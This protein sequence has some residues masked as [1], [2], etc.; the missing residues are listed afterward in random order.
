M[1]G[2]AIFFISALFKNT[3][4][5]LTISFVF[6]GVLIFLSEILPSFLNPLNLVCASSYMKEFETINFFGMPIQSFAVSIC[7][8]FIISIIFTI[9]GIKKCLKVK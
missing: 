9:A 2:S 4:L 7:I 3:G 5:A 1:F 8:T 6:A